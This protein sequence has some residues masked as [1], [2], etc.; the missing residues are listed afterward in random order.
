MMEKLAGA[1]NNQ[2]E[3]QAKQRCFFGHSGLGLEVFLFKSISN[4]CSMSHLFVLASMGISL[5]FFCNLDVQA[6][7]F[8]TKD[9]YLLVLMFRMFS[10]KE[11]KS[12][13]MSDSTS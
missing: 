1:A 6:P 10:S 4:S 5:N 8:Q 3:S 12:A 9:Y 11:M 2:R 7:P 13:S